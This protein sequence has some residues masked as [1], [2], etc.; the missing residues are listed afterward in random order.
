MCYLNFIFILGKAGI[1]NGDYM[2]VLLVFMST[3]RS[4]KA[5]WDKER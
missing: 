2:S 5:T 1:M 3:E 4:E